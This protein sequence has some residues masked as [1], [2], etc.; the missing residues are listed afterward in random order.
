MPWRGVVLGFLFLL[1]AAASAHAQR[2]PVFLEPDHWAWDAVRRLSVAGVAP[3]ASDPMEASVTYQH[4]R[5]VFAHAAAVADSLGRRDLA[6]L[7]R[8]YRLMLVAEA[9]SAGVL[10]DVRLGAGWTASRGEAL[11]GEGFFKGHDWVGTQPLPSSNH[12]AAALGAHGHVQEWLSWQVH[13]GY[14][15]DQWVIPA[16]SAGVAFGPFDAWAGRRR[17]HYGAGRGGAIVT[18]GGFNAP[19]AFAHRTLDTFEGIGLHVREP[20]RFPWILRFLGPARIEVVGGRISRNGLVDNPYLVFGR[21]TASP[22]SDRFSLGVNRGAVFGGDG[23][24]ITLSRLMGVI[25]GLHNYGFED[26][27]ISG[28]MRYRPPL[29]IVP[30]EFYLEFGADDTAGAL[31]DVPT[32]I[33]GLD[34]AAVPGLPALGVALEHTR[35]SGSCCGNPPWYRNVFFRGSWSDEGQLFAH[36]LGGHGYEWLAHARLDLPHRGLL[37]RGEAFRRWRGHENLF[38][39]EREGL[40]LGAAVSLEVRRG[41]SVLRAEGGYEDAVSWSRHH[42]SVTASHRFR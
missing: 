25:V 10:A 17:L 16:V 33:Y 22:F 13:G 14:L 30:L 40:S 34:V 36:P 12:P 2:A 20:F 27:V 1:A 24:G 3:P 19:A 26:Q 9:D 39:P 7:A 28:V 8:G 37:L 38:A 23:N 21:L 31:T 5:T 11:G 4:A 42:L 35:Y 41:N 15:A 32:Y 18:G 6:R 29:V